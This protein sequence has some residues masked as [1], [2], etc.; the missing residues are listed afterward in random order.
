VTLLAL[1]FNIA[2]GVGTLA[3]GYAPLGL[4]PFARWMICLGAAWLLALWRRWRWFDYAALGVLFLAAALGLWILDLPPGWMLSG[5]IGGVLAFDLSGFLRRLRF[6]ASDEER[7]A[8]ERRHLARIALL[9]LLG[10]GLA[11]WMMLLKSQFNRE[12]VVFL[13]L[14]GMLALLQLA[15][16][17]RR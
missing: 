10:L 3:W 4:L 17:F 1:L 5:A 7:R 2:L 13:A 12:W 8:L 16:W 11:S 14:A 15:P 9:T 6:A